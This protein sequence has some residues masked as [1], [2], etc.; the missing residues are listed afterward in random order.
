MFLR[1]RCIQ[2][3]CVVALACAGAASLTA[4]ELSPEGLWKTTDDRTGKPRGMVRIYRENGALYGRV[5]ATLDPAEARQVCDLC[6][7]ERR[8]KPVVGMIVMRGLRKNGGEYNGG[9]ILDPDTGS[10]YRCKLRIE[11]QGRKLIVRGFIGF[12]IFGRTQTWT[13]Q[14]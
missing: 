12:S 1:H 2:H 9:D 7:D 8:N 4:A 3:L 14:P 6:T 10:V 13:R 11:D 5:E